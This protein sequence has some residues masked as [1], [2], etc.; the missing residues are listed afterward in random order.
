MDKAGTSIL[1][2]GPL[3]AWRQ[4]RRSTELA[5]QGAHP[6]FPNVSAR[7]RSGASNKRSLRPASLIRSSHD[8]KWLRPPCLTAQIHL[9]E[10]PTVVERVRRPSKAAKSRSS[11]AT[12]ITCCIALQYRR[13]GAD[14]LT[15]RHRPNHSERPNK[16]AKD[17]PRSFFLDGE[18]PSMG[19]TPHSPS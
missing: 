11:P 19:N 17:S 18:T 13:S 3:A 6:V 15:R 10:Q 1:N 8:A 12:C 2:I 7:I 16:P 5:P 4:H 14:P 9:A